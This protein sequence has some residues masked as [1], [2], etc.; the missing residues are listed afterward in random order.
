MK[1]LVVNGWTEE[2][3]LDH[4]KSGCNLQK[5]IFT[6]LITSTLPNSTIDIF[7]SYNNEDYDL[8]NYNAFMWTG[9]GGN[10]Y[11]ENEHNKSQLDFCSNILKLNK[12]IWG[13]CWGM[14]VIVTALGKQVK[15]SHKPEFG[16]AKNIVIKNPILNKTI[17]KSKNI[18]FDAP[19]HHYDIIVDIPN[20][21]ES[22]AENDN[23]IQ[24]IY[25]ARKKI[26]CTQYHSELGYDYIANLMVFWKKNY[27]KIINEL[28]FD[29]L[30]N[31]LRIKEVNDNENR[32]IELKNWL[33]L[34]N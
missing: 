15:K 9:G 5:E 32:L 29:A 24:S 3:D 16:I 20:D 27:S 18:V 28:D 17:Y 33:K 34:L 8:N 4:V 31:S 11:E 25:S 19:A 14:Q 21:F 1:I 6:E 13:S 30:I 10:I 12:P 7:N 23:C 22:I 26:F 2:S